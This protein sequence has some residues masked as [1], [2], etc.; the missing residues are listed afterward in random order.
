MNYTHQYSI[1]KSLLL[2]PFPSVNSL[3]T[4]PDEALSLSINYNDSYNSQ[5]DYDGSPIKSKDSDISIGL[6]FD[7]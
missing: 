4:C 3:S 6:S 2:D 1:S 7:L 5:Y